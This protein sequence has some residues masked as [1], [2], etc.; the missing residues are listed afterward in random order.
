MCLQCVGFNIDYRC[1]H[2]LDSIATW[3]QRDVL[4]TVRSC[5]VFAACVV[6][7]V[8][9][10]AITICAINIESDLDIMRV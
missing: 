3:M 2:V 8:T 1:V 6:K 10:I 4:V 9:H 5:E 7:I